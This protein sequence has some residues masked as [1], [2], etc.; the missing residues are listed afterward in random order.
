M[1]ETN[2]EGFFEKA[3]A[4][5]GQTPDT[6]RELYPYLVPD[7]SESQQQEGKI[8]RIP[9]DSLTL[10]C[11]INK[12]DICKASYTFLNIFSEK[13]QIRQIIEYCRHTFHYN[14]LLGVWYL[15]NGTIEIKISNYVAL[16][17]VTKWYSIPECIKD[18]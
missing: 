4:A 17:V 10:F 15:E 3:Y 18:F 8:F 16:I 1:P 14:Y 6:L 5:L 13:E 9:S 11:L 2:I 7:F 12:E